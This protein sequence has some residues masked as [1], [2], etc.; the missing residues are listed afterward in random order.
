MFSSKIIFICWIIYAWFYSSILGALHGT[1]NNFF[2]YVFINPDRF[3]E[4]IRK[5]SLNLIWLHERFNPNYFIAV[6]I[7]IIIT[8]CLIGTIAL[9]KNLCSLEKEKCDCKLI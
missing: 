2:V 3:S 6:Q 8:G 4:F 9:T 7:V 5:Q 1:I